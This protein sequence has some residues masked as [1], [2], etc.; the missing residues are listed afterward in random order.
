MPPLGLYIVVQGVDVPFRR[1][2]GISVCR[3][4]DCTFVQAVDVLRYM[5]VQAVGEPLGLY[6]V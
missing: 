6:E 1:H 4:W 5:V 3:R 2:P